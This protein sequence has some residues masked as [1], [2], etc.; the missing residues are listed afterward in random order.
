MHFCLLQD[1]LRN[2][3]VDAEQRVQLHR[4]GLALLG[5]QGEDIVDDLDSSAIDGAK[6]P[7]RKRS[8]YLKS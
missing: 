2:T 3:A 1:V 8:H 7:C 4:R 6:E 5:R